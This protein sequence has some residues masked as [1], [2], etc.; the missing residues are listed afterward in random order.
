[1][2]KTFVWIT[3]LMAVISINSVAQTKD[4]AI[5]KTLNERYESAEAD[6]K[7]L[8]AREST[9]GELYSAAGDNYFYWGEIESAE[10]MF[11]KGIEM[12]STNPLNY[13][14]LGRVAW[15]KG[16]DAVNIA[17]FEKAVALMNTRS[18][19]VA[20]PVQQLTYLKMA[21]VYLQSTKKNLPKA[22]EYINLALNID[23]KNP[24][25]YVQLGEY[26]GIRDGINLSSAVKEF[27]TALTLDPKY[28]R[29]LVRKGALY[30]KIESTSQAL[31]YFNEAIAIDPTF[32][33]VY[34]EKAE[35]QYGL[36]MY[37]EAVESYKK[38]LDLNNNCRVQQRYAT[39]IF[40]TKDYKLALEELE[41]ALPCNPNNAVMYRVMGYTNYELGNYAKAQEMLDKYFEICRVKGKPIPNGEDF[42]YK[43]KTFSKLG[44]DSLSI[45]AFEEGIR[46]DSNYLDGYSDAAAVYSKLKKHDKAASYYKIKIEKSKE[47]KPL[48]YYYLGTSSYYNKDFVGADAAFA[49]CLKSYND[50][51]FWRG[52]TN[53]RMEV[54]IN[55]PTGLGKPFFEDYIRL[56]ATTPESTASNKKNLIESY[57]YLGYFHYFNKNYDCSKVAYSK[58]IE[59]DAANEKAKIALEDKDVMAAPGTCELIPVK[60]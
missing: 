58:V 53:N 28:V 35:L 33:P 52:R 55:A 2:K 43:G 57:L 24:E 13:A 42:S 23:D 1:M 10:A 29:A 41:K 30:V 12:A 16:D 48:D 54:D 49:N 22:L 9:N 26:Y 6:F 38:Y 15:F 21:E 46:Q 32:A 20:K 5:R 51:T 3:A 27:N 7:E 56:V 19:K 34:R 40:L 44:Q 45:L 17:Q 59:L 39:F 37:K 11:R 47:V 31:E 25:V 60:N 18:N 4:E 8:I 36:K 50:A 14:G